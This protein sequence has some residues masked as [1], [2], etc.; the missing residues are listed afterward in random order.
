MLIW[1]F[2]GARTSSMPARSEP[3][4]GAIQDVSAARRSVEAII[5]SVATSRGQ[6]LRGKP[7]AFGE[8]ARLLG[9]GGRFAVSRLPARTRAW[10][11]PL[12]RHGQRTVCIAGALT[13]AGYSRQLGDRRL[14]FEGVQT[15]RGKAAAPALPSIP[16]TRYAP[17]IA[18][19]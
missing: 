12:A 3:V 1:R 9:R 18:T 17:T 15:R 2:T 16:R 5:S 4:K 11:R 8:A 6:P 13:R 19:E 14:E 10:T 7:A